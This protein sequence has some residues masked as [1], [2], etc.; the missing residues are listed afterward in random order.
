MTTINGISIISLFWLNCNLHLAFKTGDTVI[1]IATKNEQSDVLEH[2]KSIGADINSCNKVNFILGRQLSSSVNNN[3]IVPAANAG[4]VIVIFSLSTLSFLFSE[5]CHGI[6][7][8]FVLRKF[9]L[10]T[11]MRSHPVGLD[12]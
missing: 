12:V 11:R 2:L 9:I 6:M 3:F 8:L 1:H 5:P 4:W 7:I 10:Q